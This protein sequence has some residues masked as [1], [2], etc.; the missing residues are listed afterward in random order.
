MP[1]TDEELKNAFRMFF[2][3]HADAA[4]ELLSQ[5]N[6]KS[7]SIIDESKQVFIAYLLTEAEKDH[8][9]GNDDLLRFILNYLQLTRS[10]NGQ[11]ISALISLTN[12]NAARG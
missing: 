7:L 4:S 1:V 8:L 12:W 5:E 6:I 3:P 2:M 9:N 10:I 11:G